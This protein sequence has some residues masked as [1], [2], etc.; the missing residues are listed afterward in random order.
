MAKNKAK[1]KQLPEAKPK[2]KKSKKYS[3]KSKKNK[4]VCFNEVINGNENE[5]ENTLHIYNINGP[6]PRHGYRIY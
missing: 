4:C 5:A 2:A 1:S 3:K 6:R